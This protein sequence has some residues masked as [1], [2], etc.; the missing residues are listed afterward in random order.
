MIVKLKPTRREAVLP[1]L[2]VYRISVKQYYRMINAG[3]FSPETRIELLEGLLVPKMTF[4]PPHPVAVGLWGD[5]IRPLLPK[6]WCVRTQSSAETSDSVP[7][8]DGAVLRGAQRDYR[9]HHP[10][11]KEVG[12]FAEVSDTTLTHD[13]TVKQRIYARARIPIYWIVNL[14]DRQVEVY[15]DPSGPTSSPRYRHKQI[16]EEDQSVPLVLDGKKVGSIAV[17]DLLP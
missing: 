7:E 5:A 13:Q 11:S 8:P 6:G 15:T 9:D 14:R 1:T 17:R 2:P 3:V 16:Y 12:M 4:N 10:R